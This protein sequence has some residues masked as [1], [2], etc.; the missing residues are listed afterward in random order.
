[1]YFAAEIAFN[2]KAIPIQKICVCFE[3][4]KSFTEVEWLQ[5]DYEEGLRQSI[6]AEV[7]E[8]VALIVREDRHLNSMVSIS[9]CYNGTTID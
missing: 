9:D 1:M 3:I 6:S 4:S 8:T 7:I 2:K 5:T